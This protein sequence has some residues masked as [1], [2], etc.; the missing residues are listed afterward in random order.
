[1]ARTVFGGQGLIYLLIIASTTLILI[2]AANTSFADFPRLGALVAADDGFLPRQL[3]FKGS[4]LVFSRA[5][6][7][8]RCLLRC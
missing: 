4:R 3:T 1:M 8:W 6:S 5:S 7:R 2:M